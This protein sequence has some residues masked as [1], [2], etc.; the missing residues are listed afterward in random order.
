MLRDILIYN[1]V[2]ILI[3]FLSVV[4]YAILTDICFLPASDK[5]QTLEYVLQRPFQEAFRVEMCCWK[6]NDW[7]KG[8]IERE[9]PRK[10]RLYKHIFLKYGLG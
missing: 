6:S 7:E 10:E 9:I 5:S 8:S 1:R 4:A 3:A 2:H